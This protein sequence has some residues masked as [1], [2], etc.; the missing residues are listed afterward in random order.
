M[1]SKSASLKQEPG[2]MVSYLSMYIYIYLRINFFTITVRYYPLHAL[3]RP[4]NFDCPR[5]HCRTK[6]AIVP[7]WRTQRPATRG[8]V[9]QH[10][11]R[12]LAR[13]L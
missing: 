1:F 11:L 4:T 10:G 9:L 13:L 2:V 12:Q 5:D 7:R 8:Y 6:Q 3:P